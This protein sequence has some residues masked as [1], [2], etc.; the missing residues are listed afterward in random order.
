MEDQPY[1]TPNMRT[2]VIIAFVLLT[3]A[4]KAQDKYNYVAYNKIIEL[5]GTEYVIATVENWGKKS[6]N[7]RYLLF[8]NTKTGESRQ[9][10]FPDD[11]YI[12]KVEQVKIDSLGINRVLVIANTVNL[13]GDKYIDW[14]DPRQVI[15]LSTDGKEKIQ[16]TEDKFFVSTWMLNRQTG[17]I[18]ITGHLDTNNNGKHD[19][20][21]KN[22][23]LLYSLAE[24]KLVTRI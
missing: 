12:G 16:V 11:A 7:N 4:T 22:E 21:D 1:K 2:A 17:A 15:I 19:K 24:M 18:V 20:T 23:I 6:V 9:V 8:I 3:V 13:D 10:D 14:N 5:Q